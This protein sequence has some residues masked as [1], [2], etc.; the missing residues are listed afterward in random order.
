MV[1]EIVTFG[2]PK[3]IRT[4]GVR[5]EDARFPP[6]RPSVFE[7]GVD[8]PSCLRGARLPDIM[9]GP[10]FAIYPTRILLQA[11]AALHLFNS[12]ANVPKLVPLRLREVHRAEVV[13]RPVA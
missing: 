7:P 1:F 6:R 8:Q 2:G 12:A 11:S 3:G 10:Y 9:F 5:R 13:L 4:G